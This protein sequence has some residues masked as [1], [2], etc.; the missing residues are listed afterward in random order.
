MY[1]VAVLNTRHTT[2]TPC[3][4]CG[5]IDHGWELHKHFLRGRCK[6]CGSDEHRL[7]RTTTNEH[8]ELIT[9]FSCP[10]SIVAGIE[11]TQQLSRMY[12]KYRPCA[13]K[14]AEHYAYNAA[15]VDKALKD[16]LNHG[17]GGYLPPPYP[18]MFL[19]EVTQICEE[20][21]SSWTFKR[22]SI[23]TE[24]SDDEEDTEEL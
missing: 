11:A 13:S 23:N 22:T 10:V 3:I 21:R 8:G 24:S 20:V 9:E 14:F 17:L 16:F 2:E 12:L 19:T 7:L 18:S 15:Q 1:M 6:C 4:Q 5:A